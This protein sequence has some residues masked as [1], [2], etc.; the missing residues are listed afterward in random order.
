MVSGSIAMNF[1]AQPRM[2]RDIDIIVELTPSAARRLP[3]LFSPD[4][5]VD[6]DDVNEAAR[7]HGMFNIIHNTSIVKVDF[8]VRKEDLYRKT[9]FERRRTASIEGASINIVSPEDLLLS[10]LR[11]ARDGDSGMQLKDARNIVQSRED[12]DWPYL[13][14]WAGELEIKDLLH[15]SKEK[16]V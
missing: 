6:S 12:L 7:D 10:K 1:Y 13:E 2:T 15:R 9:E 4:F 14:Q 11:W 5:Y 16:D 8:I 3:A